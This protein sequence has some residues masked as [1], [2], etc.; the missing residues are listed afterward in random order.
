LNESNTT[1]QS[2]ADE[3]LDALFHQIK[4][5]R[6]EMLLITPPIVLTV[7]LYLRAGLV[8]AVAALTVLVA[9]ALGVANLR[10]VIFGVLHRSSV[11]CHLET[12]FSSLPGIL[13]ERQP[14]VKS[15]RRTTF[16]DR[17]EVLLAKGTS[18]EDLAKIESVLASPLGVRQVR[19]RANDSKRNVVT[20]SITRDDRA[21]DAARVRARPAPANRGHNRT[22][23]CHSVDTW[24]TSNEDVHCV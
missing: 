8:V 4:V 24:L 1:Q 19:C 12:A 11:R 2:T 3:V 21:R 20:L 23:R 10:R 18:I 6:V 16:E 13:G 14:K 15:I 17:V 9:L 5:W 22:L 7:W